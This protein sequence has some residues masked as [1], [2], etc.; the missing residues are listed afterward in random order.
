MTNRNC[1]WFDKNLSFDQMKEKCRI[2]ALK[3]DTKREFV[4]N[5]NTAYVYA[6]IIN[7]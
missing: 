1:K 5:N 7:I 6:V 3:Y 2:E 4:A